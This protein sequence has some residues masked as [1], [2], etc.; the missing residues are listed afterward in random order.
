MSKRVAMTGQLGRRASRQ[1]GYTMV[2]LVMA[3][4]IFA[5]GITG[6]AAMQTATSASNRHAKNLAVASAIARTWQEELAIDAL[7]W[8]SDNPLSLANNTTWLN[9]VAA[10]PAWTLPAQNAGGTMGPSF[11][12]VGNFTTIAASTAFCVHIRLTRLLN[13]VPGTPNGLIRSE[14]RVLWPKAG[15]DWETAGNFCALPAAQFRGFD[16]GSAV[17]ATGTEVDNFHFVYAT[18]AVRE[19]PSE[20]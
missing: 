20:F 5:I 17:T 18:S 12:P 1:R 10:P 14:V 7:R 9:I 6:V 3:M 13:S 2:E 19:T 16:A 11:D 8:T 15:Y 4:G